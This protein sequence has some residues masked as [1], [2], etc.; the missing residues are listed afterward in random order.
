MKVVGLINRIYEG[1]QPKHIRFDTEEW[2][3]GYDSYVPENF[4]N[5]SPDVQ[6]SVS[7]F[8]R[9]RLDYCLND[10]VE[11]LDNKEVKSLKKEDIEA[12]GYACGKIKKT[13]ENGWNKALN[14]EPLEDEDK[15][16]P[17]IPDDELWSINGKKG[18]IEDANTYSEISRDTA[19]N[20]N[21]KVLKEKINQV[22]EELNRRNNE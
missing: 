19:I 17:L 10:E 13:F 4:L 14:N 12:L 18:I 9:Y 3:W 22:V 21:F 15:D 16:I 5:L 11:D 6:T 8:Q 7:L 1:T 20:Y 2:F